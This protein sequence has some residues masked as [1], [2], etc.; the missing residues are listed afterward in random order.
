MAI[1]FS[2]PES[3][4]SYTVNTISGVNFHGLSHAHSG[5]LTGW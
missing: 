2:F 4:N 1:V 5:S 3:A